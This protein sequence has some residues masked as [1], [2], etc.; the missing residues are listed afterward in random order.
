MHISIN[1]VR[2]S[3]LQKRSDFIKSPDFSVEY[4]HF[5]L[6][7]QQ[8]LQKHDEFE[9]VAFCWPYNHEPDLR[10]LLVE[11]QTSQSN[12]EL[13]LPKIEPNKHLTFYT[14][15]KSDD[16]I[17]NSFGILE[18]NPFARGV[19][20]KVPD[21]IFI[22][23]VG[24]LIHGGKYWRLGYGGGYFDRTIKALKHEGYIF[25]TVGVA[26]NWQEITERE[27]LP[28]DHDQPLDYILT[29]NGLRG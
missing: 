19:K 10:A 23:C 9:S 15:S 3:L 17:N 2:K 1:Q 18:P 24:W 29:N 20:R 4:A 8:F 14:W 27:W 5:L 25:T 26:F 13:L 28:L 7:L 16:L 12:R 6:H 21:C 11:W 22:P